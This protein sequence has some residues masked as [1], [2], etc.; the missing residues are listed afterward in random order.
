[1]ARKSNSYFQFRQFRVD[2][3][4]CAM[5]V[6]LDACLFGASIEVS[7]SKRILDIGTG[8]GL[9]S[10]MAAQRCNAKIDAV[11]LDVDAMQQ[12]KE[13]FR[14]SPWRERLN[15]IH[16]A[17]QDL[18]ET[19]ELYDTIICNP[20]FF[21]NALKAP[22]V[23]RNMARH[24]CS[25]SFDDLARAIDK[26]LMKSGNAWLLLPTVSTPLFL[27]AIRFYP[28]LQFR[29]QISVRSKPSRKDHRHF[30]AITKQG[31]A[32]TE[33]ESFS[34]HTKSGEYSEAVKKR[35]SEYYAKPLT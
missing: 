25:L 10:L 19:D 31:H 22:D 21:D 11:E 2:Q 9:L 34:I 24:T 35:L 29:K 13:N 3:G 20:P 16:S 12:A 17:V 27:E 5:K 14:Q 7:D 15:V 18:P 4:Q 28:K 33:Y 23:Q 8:T 26:Q 30:L 1:M 32:T 6:T